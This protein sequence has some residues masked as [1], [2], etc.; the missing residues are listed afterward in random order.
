MNMEKEPLVSII[1]VNFEG[2]KLLEKCLKSLQQTE[3]SSFEIII[4]DNQSTDDSVKFVKTNYPDIKIIELNKNYGFSVPN[5]I[6]AKTA[7]GKYLV[8]L[9]NDTMVTSSWLS[10][11]VTVMDSDK[12]IAIGQSLLLKSDGSIES[13][14]DFIDNFG[15][16]YS[17]TQIPTTTSN[18][19]SARAACMIIRKDIF[20]ELG[21]F[22]ENFFVSFEDVELGW[23]SWLL[24]YRVVVVP[25]SKVYHHGG[26]TIKK[27]S[28]T[29]AF[30]GVKNYFSLLITHFE[31]SIFF[32]N[33]FMIGLNAIT[34]K[35]GV[36]LINKKTR[37]RYTSP[38]FK[39]IIKASIWILMNFRKIIHK[40]KKLQ[41]NKVR[42][43]DELRNLGLITS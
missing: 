33:S 34:Q 11:L 3:Y 25:T 26:Q 43:N 29:I 41:S 1:I 12:T 38:D 23:K 17:R 15:I 20:L 21:G 27:M 28:K 9:N 7:K 42:T 24:G 32:K 39:T 37:T 5:N 13:S 10:E 36:N 4:V 18:I 16:P 40:R 14:G 35:F 22:D 30:H 31:F 2:R 8:F 19:L 6:A